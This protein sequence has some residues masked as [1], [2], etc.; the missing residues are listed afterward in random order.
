MLRREFIAGLGSAAAWP[1]VARA[2]QG[3]RVRRIGV[4]MEFDEHDPV[5]QPYVSAFTQALA[6]LGWTDSRNARMDLRWGGGDSDVNRIR[7]LA[8][9]LVGL[10][11]DII[12]THTTP[13]TVAVQRET[14]TIPIVFANVAD[15]VASGIVAR[16]NQPGGNTTGFASYEASLGG[17]WLELL[18]EI[19]PGLKRAAIMFNSNMVT[20]STQAPSFETGG[21][22]AWPVVARGQQPIMPVIGFLS[23]QSSELDYKDATVPFLSG[24]K[25]TGY[26]EGQNV[27]IEHRWAENQIDRLPALAADLVRRRVAVIVANGTTVAVPAKAATTT[28]PIVFA[29]GGDPVALGL[30]ASLNRP[31]ANVTGIA[32]LAAELAPKQLQLLHELIPDAARFG[33][34]TNPAELISVIAELQ[35]AARTLG[36]QLVAVNARTDA[37]LVSLIEWYLV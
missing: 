33:V 35:A 20:A 6:G 30:V 11:P 18:S 37:D 21:A 25:E 15:P 10:Q 1:V 34:L 24:L 28:I 27:A 5:Q 31:G 19:A 7:P 36:L 26:V 2:Q 8:Q 4:L 9:K 3:D 22:A 32:N 23:A 14:Q 17:K 12:L 13:A 16:L 29:G